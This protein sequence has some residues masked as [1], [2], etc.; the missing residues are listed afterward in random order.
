MVVAQQ[1][2]DQIFITGGFEFLKS[3]FMPKREND[4]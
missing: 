1:R 4:L 3:N 2:S